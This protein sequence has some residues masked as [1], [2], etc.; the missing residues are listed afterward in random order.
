M[1]FHVDLIFKRMGYGNIWH[2]KFLQ[3]N[4]KNDISLNYNSQLK[5]NSYYTCVRLLWSIIPIYIL[6]TLLIYMY[7]G[8]GQIISVIVWIFY[9]PPSSWVCPSNCFY[10]YPSPRM[11]VPLQQSLAINELDEAQIGRF[12]FR[13]RESMEDV[14]FLFMHD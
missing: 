6:M 1:Y 12:S 5:K 8:L 11:S 2:I 10:F 4:W 14:S 9:T 3:L 7:K 13:T